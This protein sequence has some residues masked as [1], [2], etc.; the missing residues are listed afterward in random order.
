MSG[1]VGSVRK[2]LIYVLKA[3][4]DKLYIADLGVVEA[5]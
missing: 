4:K 3:D 1:I 5:T 2:L